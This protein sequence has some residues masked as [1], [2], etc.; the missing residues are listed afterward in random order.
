MKLFS[1]LPFGAVLFSVVLLAPE[2]SLARTSLES[3]KSCPSG[4]E[5]L[6]F[7]YTGTDPDSVLDEEVVSKIFKYCMQNHQ[8]TSISPY[9]EISVLKESDASSVR[10]LRKGSPLT[11]RLEP[12]CRRCGNGGGCSDPL[13]C[14]RRLQDKTLMT[15]SSTSTTPLKDSG[16]YHD[17]TAIGK[18]ICEDTNWF[19]NSTGVVGRVSDCKFKF[20]G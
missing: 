1:K 5:C 17:T 16:A 10:R 13:L 7:D 11:R 6:E 18:C 19:M 20:C 2:A 12:V 3:E 4:T 8:D 9:K 15:T 14:R